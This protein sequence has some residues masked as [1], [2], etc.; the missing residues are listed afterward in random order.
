MKKYFMKKICV[1][2]AFVM[3]GMLSV[4]PVGASN[5]EISDLTS[6]EGMDF[7][8]VH[9][10]YDNGIDGYSSPI[11]TEDE[12]NNILELLSEDNLIYDRPVLSKDPGD[13]ANKP[14]VF[15]VYSDIDDNGV[16]WD[17]YFDKESVLV[18]K[19][20]T[21]K[22]TLEQGYFTFRD[23]SKYSELYEHFAVLAKEVTK[24]KE[25]LLIHN[26]KKL[27]SAEFDAKCGMFSKGQWG[28]ISYTDS[29]E[30]DDIIIG[31]YF[32]VEDSGVLNEFTWDSQNNIIS[33]DR[34]AIFLVD[35]FTSNEIRYSMLPR[36]E[37]QTG[38]IKMHIDVN[39]ENE[40][41]DVYLTI[42]AVNI[43]P[44]GFEVDMSTYVEEGTLPDCDEFSFSPEHNRNVADDT[45]VDL[46]EN[47]PAPDKSNDREDNNVKEPE[48]LDETEKDEERPQITEEP[49]EPAETVENSYSRE[50]IDDNS[51]EDDI[52]PI[53]AE[54]IDPS[55]FMKT[56]EVSVYIGG[57]LLEFDQPPIIENDRVLVPMRK[58]FEELGAEVGWDGESKTVTAT[59]GDDVVIIKIDDNEMKLND[60][61]ILLDTPAKIKNDRTLV[62]IRAVSEAFNNT[63][64]WIAQSNTVTISN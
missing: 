50:D 53:P 36:E 43:F 35:D 23:N 31:A 3:T 28:I 39:E 16:S 26:V 21:W 12:E 27:Y 32:A 56:D 10:D 58:I 24:K 41:T 59:K 22:Y 40:I 13:G 20:N 46:P 19:V 34:E 60:E 33:W 62:P 37:Y 7:N 38:Y 61:T 4:L 55:E 25:E 15:T 14:N 30:S 9:I 6:V 42:D 17:F 29:P 1:F 64:S 2:L 45:Q 18:V 63:V 8:I 11:L 51:Q 44:D 54:E 49:K 52:S 48:N 57:R 47:T 5:V